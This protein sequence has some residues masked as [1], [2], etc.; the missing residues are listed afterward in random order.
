[1][2]KHQKHICIYSFLLFAISATSLANAQSVVDQ[3]KSTR[4]ITIAHRDASIPFSYLIDGEKPAGY[5]LDICLKLIE[6]IRRELALPTLKVEY[7]SVT[8][9]S[10]I[11]SIVEGKAALE[12]GSTTNTLERRKDVDF[13]IPHFLASTRFLVRKESKIQRKEDL[14][15]LRVV[16]TKGSTSLKMVQRFNAELPLKMSVIEANDH[17]EAFTSIVQ[18]KADAFA[19]DDV[20]LHGLRANSQ[21]QNELI[22]VG[23]P[24]TIE[25]YAIMIP[26]GDVKLK[27]IVDKEMRRIISS[28]EIYEMFSKWFESPIPPNGIN[29]NLPM[30]FLLRDSFKYPSDKVGD[31]N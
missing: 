27:K 31:I 30:P 13:T 18:K 29:L 16:S 1:M 22:I 23:K 26:K 9:A 24:L 14:A 17:G 25:P 19:M 11:P 8:S 3:I 28:G 12:C 15:G 20:L 5:S 7:L 10:R 4:S 21:Y 6:A 2:Q